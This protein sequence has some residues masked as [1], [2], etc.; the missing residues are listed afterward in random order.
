MSNDTAISWTDC[1][2]NII[3]VKGGGWHCQKISAGCANCYAEALNQNTFFGGNKLPYSGE[4][5]DLI[6]KR[7][8]F[9]SWPRQ[10]KPKKHFVA[11]MTD[12]FG[13]W[14][15]PTWHEEILNAMW[16]SPNQTFQILTKRPHIM[17]DRCLQWMKE[18]GLPRMPD[19]IW[20]GTTVENQAVAGD[21][22][23]ALVEIPAKIHFL[24]CEP[25]L[26]KID[27]TEWIKSLQWVITGGESGKKARPCHIDWVRS[28]VEQCQFADIPVFVK[29]LGSNPVD[30]SPYIDGVVANNYRFSTSDSKGS[31]LCDFPEDL[32]IRQ[33]PYA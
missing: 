3:V 21:R 2:D 1:T 11:S 14:I 13:E 8:I 29:Q 12:V 15:D 9:Q 17:R 10:R 26:E 25:L 33:F 20:V 7:D 16:S 23:P 32:R 24:S 28:L 18:W 4:P 22:I 19:N 6:L 5:P 27:L 31:D 30:S